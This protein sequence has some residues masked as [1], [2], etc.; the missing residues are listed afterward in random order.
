MYILRCKGYAPNFQSN[1]EQRTQSE[2]VHLS[3]PRGLKT[4]ISHVEKS[5]NVHF[6]R[7]RVSLYISVSLFSAPLRMIT[8]FALSA[9]EHFRICNSFD[10]RFVHRRPF[11]FVHFDPL[12]LFITHVKP[13]KTIENVRNRCRFGYYNM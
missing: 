4:Y 10:R 13:L 6:H 9:N 11:C 5:V 7:Q 8:S 2:N 3:V 1:L 12:V